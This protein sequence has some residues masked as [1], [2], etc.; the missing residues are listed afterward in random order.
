[1]FPP[2]VRFFSAQNETLAKQARDALQSLKDDKGVSILDSKM[3]ESV[4][5]CD[6]NEVTVKIQLTKNYRKAK[7][8]I[9]TQLQGSLPWV[10]KV[11]VGM[12]AQKV[13]TNDQQQM[14]AHGGRMQGL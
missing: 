5:V 8:L 12:A 11:N 3:V 9:Q 2:R 10:T 4:S 13:E 14:N 7:A 1:M 6:N